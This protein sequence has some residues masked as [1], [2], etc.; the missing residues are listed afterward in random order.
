MQRGDFAT[1]ICE[2]A[3]KFSYLIAKCDW[4]FSLI[5][6]P[7]MTFFF[8]L[9]HGPLSSFCGLK[10]ADHMIRNSF[11]QATKDELRPNEI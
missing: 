2:I 9:L 3:T 8:N 7:E 10:N 11:S 1:K 4:I 6:S 5:S